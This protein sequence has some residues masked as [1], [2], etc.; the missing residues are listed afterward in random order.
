[1]TREWFEQIRVGM[2]REEVIRTVGASPGDYSV[3]RWP[4]HPTATQ[5]NS[6][7]C[8][9]AELGID[10]DDAGTAVT[11]VILPPRVRTPA[12]TEPIRRWLG[13]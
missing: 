4:I 1:M 8:D 9:D 7:T 3:G 5:Q 2:L 10:F 13:L 11:V 6:W 12:L